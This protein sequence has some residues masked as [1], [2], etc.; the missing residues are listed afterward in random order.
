MAQRELP[1]H[2]PRRAGL[3]QRVLQAVLPGLAQEWVI[4]GRNNGCWCRIAAYRSHVNHRPRVR[5][6]SSFRQMRRT[7]R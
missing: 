5:R 2:G 3:P 4:R 1:P 7:L 6:L